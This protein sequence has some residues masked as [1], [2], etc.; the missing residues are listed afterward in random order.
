MKGSWPSTV[1][2]IPLIRLFSIEISR[3]LSGLK[4]IGLLESEK[5]F[6]GVNTK[7]STSGETIGPPAA[8]EYKD[9]VAEGADTLHLYPVIKDAPLVEED[10]VVYVQVNGSNLTAPEAGLLE[11]RFKSTLDDENVKF[12]VIEGAAD[13]FKDAIGDDSDVIIGGN[14][15][16]NSLGKHADGPTANAGAKH[17]A[18]TNRKVIISDKC[19]DAHLDLAKKLYNFV[20]SDAIEFELTAAFWPKNED[21]VTADEETAMI[22]GMTDHLNTLLGIGETETLL[23]KY[24]VTLSTQDVAGTKVANLAADT[25]ALNEGKGVDLIIGC[26]KNVD[27]Q[28]GL[29]GVSK[30]AVT[31]DFMAAGRYVA[32]VH[33][34]YLARSIFADYFVE[35]AA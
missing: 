28:V 9:L 2:Q 6:K 32:L 26:D 1:R 25:L 7:A 18:S 20:T 15:P 13:A 34:N 5:E 3:L 24:N 19:S 29:T 30:K 35:L 8:A 12:N 10:L 27:E 21:W 16:V 11:A 22:K 14:N 17:F 33:D 31:T 23:D 4:T